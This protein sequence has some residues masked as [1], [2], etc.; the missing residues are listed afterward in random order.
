VY[1]FYPGL[2]SKHG[3][4]KIFDINGRLVRRVEI[5]PGDQKGSFWDGK[6]DNGHTCATG[7][8]IYIIEVNGKR[9]CSGSVT[10]AR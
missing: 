5:I 10:L 9:L 6:G 7:T 1:F 2:Y 4:L 8:Y 3:V